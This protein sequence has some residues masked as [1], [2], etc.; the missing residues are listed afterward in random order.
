MPVNL[1]FLQLYSFRE[2][3]LSNISLFGI[4]KKKRGTFSVVDVVGAL[5]EQER[6]RGAGTYW[7]VLKKSLK[8][9]ENELLTICKQLKLKAADDVSGSGI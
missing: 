3:F 1:A 8:E 9:E 7:A 5:T 4:T 2:L 6:P